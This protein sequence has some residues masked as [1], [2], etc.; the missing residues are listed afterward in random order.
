LATEIWGTRVTRQRLHWLKS[1]LRK[2]EVRIR[3]RHERYLPNSSC[4]RLVEVSFVMQ[5][6]LTDKRADRMILL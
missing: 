3:R 1:S 2:M 4:T 5:D 6:I